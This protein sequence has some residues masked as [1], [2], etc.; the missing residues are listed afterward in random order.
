MCRFNGIPVVRMV[1]GGELVL[2]EGVVINSR[3]FSNSATL[4]HRTVLSVLQP[5]AAIILGAGSGLSGA[6]IV[7]TNRVEIGEDTLI[8][9]GAI[10]WDTDF[11]PLDPEQRRVHQTQGAASAAIHIGRDVFVGARAMILKGVTI[12]DGAVVGAGAVVTKN[13]AARAVVV[14]NPARV[15]SG[16][17]RPKS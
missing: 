10:I 12:G 2:G 7:A 5:G 13:V 17:A 8:G 4:P 1:R 16:D 14:G 15:V 3:Q 9:S 6:S 11:H